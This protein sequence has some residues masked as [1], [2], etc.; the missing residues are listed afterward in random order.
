[1]EGD[2]RIAVDSILSDEEGNFVF[3]GKAGALDLYDVRIPT[4]QNILLV[5]GTES[6]HISGDAL[7]LQQIQVDGGR[8]NAIL[9]QFRIRQGQLYSVYIANARKMSSINREKEQEFWR[10][11]EAATDISLMAYLDFLRTFTDTVSVP[12]LRGLAAMSL[13]VADDH[14]R[15]GVLTQRLE[16]ELPGHVITRTM[17][18]AFDKDLAKFNAFLVDDFESTTSTGAKVHFHQFHGKVVLFHVWASY[19]EY[20]RRENKR[21]AALMRSRDFPDFEVVDYSVDDNLDEWRQALAEDS[22]PWTQHLISPDGLHCFPVDEL[23]IRS[24]PFSYLI[25]RKGILRSKKVFAADL[26]HDLDSLIRKY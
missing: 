12:L 5:P 19:C 23:G 7:A 13:K 17:R 21:L 24:I 15:Y 3:E 1:M 26:E 11:Q 16:R 6:I 4:Y 2:V 25:D 9:H 18:A 20:S 14:Y 8:V 22:L 10:K